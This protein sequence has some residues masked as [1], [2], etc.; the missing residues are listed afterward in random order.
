MKGRASKAEKYRTD[1]GKEGHMMFAKS[2]R[3]EGGLTLKKVPSIRPKS[4]KHSKS[5]LAKA[6]KHMKEHGG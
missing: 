6:H 2:K 3:R 5:G 1:E 4:H